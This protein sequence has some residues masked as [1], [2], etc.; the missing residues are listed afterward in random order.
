MEQVTKRNTILSSRTLQSSIIPAFSLLTFFQLPHSR[1]FNLPIGFN[2]IQTHALNCDIYVCIFISHSW[3]TWRC[4]WLRHCATSWKDTSLNPD[5]VIWQNPSG[6]TM[7]LGSTQ[8]LTKISTRNTSCQVKAAGAW[9]WQPYHFHVPTVLKSGS[10]NLLEPSGP[11][12]FCNGM[13]LH[14]QTKTLLFTNM[15]H[16]YSQ[17]P[18]GH[19]K[20]Y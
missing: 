13:A 3:G 4:N 17:P 7:A 11:V 5:G 14:T 20:E 8:S 9:G 12:Q 18:S 15:F 19:L 10:L 2:M 16:F 1:T 6:S